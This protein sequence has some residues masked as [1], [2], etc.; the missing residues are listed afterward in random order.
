MLRSTRNLFRLAEWNTKEDQGA[1]RI[2]Q[3]CSTQGKRMLSLLSPTFQIT[4]FVVCTVA[5]TQALPVQ[6]AQQT[7]VRASNRFAKATI[8]KVLRVS[9]QGLFTPGSKARRSR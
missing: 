4:S 2:K 8:A 3:H 9:G 7:R 6:E 5:E 1:F